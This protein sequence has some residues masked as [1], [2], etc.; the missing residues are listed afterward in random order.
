M[1]GA[2]EDNGLADNTVVIFTSDHGDGYAAHRW[3]QKSV[4]Y[5]ESCRIPFIVRWP[6]G[7]RQ[8]ET[9][10]RLIS[11]GIDLM[12]TISDIVNVRM[13]QGPYYGK[14]ALPFVFSANSPASTHEYVVSEAEVRLGPNV[15]YHG[16]S[17]R[18]P[19]YKYHLW[20]RG[21]N[22]EQLFDMV[23]DP[24]ETRNLAGSPDYAE[25]LEEHREL[26]AEWLK[27][28]DDTYREN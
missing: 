12:A 11:V 23:N 25:Q 15:S 13:P 4:L 7:A 21:E 28:R 16:R 8:D 1:L 14:S 6:G 2:L 5:D 17:L 27:K 24:G 18:T 26:L 9:D 3:H 22:R 20:S 19:E 10:N